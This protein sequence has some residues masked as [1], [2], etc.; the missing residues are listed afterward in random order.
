MKKKILIL[1]ASSFIGR[2]FLK[3]LG[4]KAIGTYYKNKINNCLKFDSVNQDLSDIVRSPR[5]IKA[6]IILLG[7]THPDSCAKDKMRSQIINVE[8]IKKIIK[9]LNS[10][11]VP[12]VFTST[13]FVFDGKLGNYSE[14]EKP[15][16]IL[17]Y[18]KQK[19]AVEKYIRQHY[20]Q[21]IIVRLGKVYGSEI[22]DGTLF[23]NWIKQ[24]KRGDKIQVAGDQIFS[25]VYVEDVIKTILKLLRKKKWGL[26]HLAN[27]IGFSRLTLLKMLLKKT[28]KHLNK[29]IIVTSCSI[30]DF[31]LLEKRPK[32]VSLNTKKLRRIK[33]IVI[34]PVSRVCDLIVRKYF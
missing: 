4:D 6:A 32:N 28:E 18:G 14:D 9:V 3:K 29:N 23:T 22:T 12:F 16:P 30:D 10:W 11:K 25:P 26:F 34:C 20:R 13:E 27:E 31:P 21:Y 17:T 2:H 1:G 15:K 5:S 24:I 19:L 8:S 33:G 7:D